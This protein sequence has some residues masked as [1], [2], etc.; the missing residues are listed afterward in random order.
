M[1]VVKEVERWRRIDRVGMSVFLVPK[2][3]QLGWCARRSE[4]NVL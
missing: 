1:V 2:G 4:L 3:L